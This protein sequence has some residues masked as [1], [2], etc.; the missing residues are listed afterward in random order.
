M[1]REQEHGK[2]ESGGAR[3]PQIALVGRTNVGKSTLFNRFTRSRRALVAPTPGLTRDRREGI[4]RRDGWNFR[5]VDTGGMDPRSGAPFCVEIAAQVEVAVDGADAVWFVVDGKEGV[6]PLDEELYRWLLRQGK[7]L[8]T[9][10]NKIERDR[11]QDEMAEFFV[12]GV[13][14]LFPVSALEGSGLSDLLEATSHAIPSMIGPGE[15][16]GLAGAPES[17]RVALVGKPNVGK[18][19]L[20]NAILG[21]TRMIVSDIPG[22]TREPVDVPFSLEGQRYTLIDT[23]G[24][25]R[26]A[27]TRDPIDKVSTLTSIGAL[28]RCD[29]AVL[30]LDAWQG[31]AE[32]DLKIAGY[33]QAQNR[34][35]VM[36]LNKWDVVQEDREAAQSL[37]R[38]IEE[39]LRFL[40]FA[41]LVRTNALQGEGIRQLLNEVR[42][43]HAQFTREIQTADLNRVVAMSTMHHPPPGEGRSATRIYY[44]TQ[45]KSR[46]PLIRLFANH[47]ERLVGAYTRYLINQFR[48][49]FGLQ[50]T[51]IGIEW[52]GKEAQRKASL[53]RLP[54]RP[55]G[56]AARLRGA[57][58]AGGG[59][60]V[61]G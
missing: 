25:R 27:K 22:T 28:E 29:V 61:Q 11:R 15:E 36:A 47:P 48:Y 30:V 45:V 26:R 20:V 53:S 43:A 1:N 59:R 17:I 10:V 3:I 8:F 57:G 51:P 4:I 19:S 21:E 56:A 31:L 40:E 52:K 58:R 7:P 23:A 14:T 42:R 18:S 41:P 33:I 16:P 49:H 60:R 13:E 55:R 46:P 12:L 9:L 50:G 34:S 32:Q 38:G 6:T 35:A 54:P 37:V 2:P 24:I 44:G 39:R 5:L